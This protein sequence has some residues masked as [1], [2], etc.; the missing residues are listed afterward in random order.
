[1]TESQFKSFKRGNEI[2]SV[3]LRYVYIYQISLQYLDKFN[4]L[5]SDTIEKVEFGYNCNL[6]EYEVLRNQNV[7]LDFINW[8]KLV[9]LDVSRSKLN[10]TNFKIPH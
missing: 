4:E 5:E 1:L 9:S 7:H 2:G 3:L 8:R 6:S 10:P